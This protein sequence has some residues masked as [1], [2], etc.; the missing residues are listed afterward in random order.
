M[1]ER[2]GAKFLKSDYVEISS[3][4]NIVSTTGSDTGRCYPHIIFERGTNK[5]VYVEIYELS[6]EDIVKYIDPI[7]EFTGKDGDPYTRQKFLT[8]SWVEAFVYNSNWGIWYDLEN[9]FGF[10]ENNQRF[11]NW[12]DTNIWK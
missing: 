5:Y 2:A 3:M 7:E 10:E 8:Q 4:R 6:I 9:Y 1:L 12:Q 11:Y